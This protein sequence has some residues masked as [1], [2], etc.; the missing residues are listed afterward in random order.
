MREPGAY[1]G[2]YPS[3]SSYTVADRCQ[4]LVANGARP[5]AN[6]ATRFRKKCGI[7]I[8][9]ILLGHRKLNTTEIYAEPNT[10]ARRC[11]QLWT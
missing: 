2:R 6:A 9:R 1:A 5:E 10:P 11:G 4:A 3:P 8:A 7:E